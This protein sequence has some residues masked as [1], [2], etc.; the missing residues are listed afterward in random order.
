MEN[1][2]RKD[3]VGRI[4]PVCKSGRLLMDDVELLNQTVECFAC[5]AILPRHVTQSEIIEWGRTS[6]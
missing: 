3:L 1:E 2:S 6:E 5:G 4:C